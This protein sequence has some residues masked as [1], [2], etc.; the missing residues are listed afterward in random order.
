[1]ISDFDKALETLITNG[2]SAKLC[3]G[4]PF[5][6]IGGSELDE[7]SD[8][9]VYKDGFNICLEENQWIVRLQ[10]PGQIVNEIL[11]QDLNS[12][13]A[14]VLDSYRKNVEGSSTLP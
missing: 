14:L 7:S 1:M 9:P 11:A 10:R 8:I 6:I 4:L 13:V 2:L 12:A 3:R 5:G